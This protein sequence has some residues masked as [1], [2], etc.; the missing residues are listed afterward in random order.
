MDDAP[1]S[2]DAA[3][4]TAA[5]AAVTPGLV[6]GWL[7]FCLLMV[8]VGIQEELFSGAP[9]LGWRVTDELI[10]MT[11][12]TVVAVHRWRVGPSADALLT[13]PA[14]WFKRAVAW[15]PLAALL[16]VV[17]VYGVRHALRGLFGLSYEHAPWPAVLAYEGLKFSVFYLLFAGVQFGLRS[18]Q[19]LAAERIR[20]EQLRH[21]STEA[22]LQQL[23][24]QMQPH[25]LF[26]ALN[27]IASQVHQDPDGADASLVRLAALLRAATDV[28]QRPQHTLADE[29]ALAHAYADLMA[30][31]FG[32]RVRL[33]WHEGSAPL[34]CTVPAMA[35][36]PLLENAFVHGVERHR[37][38]TRIEV[39]VRRD[40]SRV[41]IEVADD[42][43]TLAPEWHDG[44]GLGNLRQRLQVLHG[45][46]AT[47]TLA[48]RAEGGV[49]AVL[50]LPIDVD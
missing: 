35:L 38:T 50:E 6:F 5:P 3:G 17:A 37:G 49:S 14:R 40:R 15:V 46:A 32:D 25:F 42:A 19:A 9:D 41:R 13:Q 16:F 33:T 43:G 2:Q 23:T 22:R 24:Q 27:T 39:S 12:A 26:N 31:R 1:H 29:L 30:Q 4:L 45:G 8:L 44:V 47:L 11:A 36:Q 21:L 20:S 10:S 48:T 34:R 28:A 18:Y 7:A